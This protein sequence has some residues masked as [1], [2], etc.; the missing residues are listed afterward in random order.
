MLK[1]AS[2]GTTG[3]YGHGAGQPALENPPKTPPLPQ[4]Y[5]GGKAAKPYGGPKK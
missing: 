3:K 5:G 4:G 1:K 2:P